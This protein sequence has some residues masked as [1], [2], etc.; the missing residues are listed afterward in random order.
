MQFFEEFLGL[1]PEFCITFLLDNAL[2]GN[3]GQGHYKTF[4]KPLSYV[5]YHK[6]QMPLLFKCDI[7]KE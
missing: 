1:L 4:F 2:L 3:Q 6:W 5:S 7:R